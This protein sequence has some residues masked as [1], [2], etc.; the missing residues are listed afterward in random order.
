MKRLRAPLALC[1]CLLLLCAL[2]APALAAEGP[3]PYALTVEIDGREES[4]V[5]AF[6]EGYADN[7][8]L[9][10][11]DLSQA[12]DGTEKQFR[13]QY[14]SNNTDG[15]SFTLL[16]GQRAAPIDSSAPTPQA[17]SSTSILGLSRHRLFVDKSERKV[18]SYRPLYRDLYLGLTDVQLMLDLTAEYLSPGRIRLYPE[19]PFAPEIRELQEAGYF[20]PITSYLV[21]DAE[22][23]KLLYSDSAARVAPV[24]SLSKLM[25][26]LLF[27]EALADGRMAMTDLVKISPEAAALSRS[28]DGI[29]P[30]DAGKQVPVSELMDGMLLA[31]SNESALALA[32]YL[33]G[34]E[35]A[36]VE[37]MNRR[38]EELGYRSARFYTPHGLPVY[39]R[40]AVTAKLQNCM[41]A[42]ELFK[43]CRLLLT[44]YPELTEITRQKFARLESLEYTTANSNPLVFNLEGVDGLKTGSTN[45]AG[46]CLA[47]SM[48]VTHGGDT[49]EIVLI[50]L[51]AETAELRGQAAEILLRAAQR[52]YEQNGF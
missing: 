38:A 52:H 34:S 36:F 48:P 26:Y 13:V 21:A 12:L 39:T 28:A 37:Q 22:T 24:A 50:L 44:Q 31:S 15:E 30:M 46:Y 11:A 23:G 5:R 49:H 4:V 33:C 7:L 1:L 45:R 16:T 47:A 8:Y 14:A 6:S 19:R 2:S 27:A 42:M 9:S 40:S 25:S 35:V 51:G 10:L 18:Y 29:I 17:K 41:S 20:E 32:E 3:V 43:L